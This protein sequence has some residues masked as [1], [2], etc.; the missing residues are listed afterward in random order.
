MASSNVSYQSVA[1]K[2]GILVGVAH[3]IFFLL[4]WAL[5]LLEVTELSFV[6]GLFLVI[7][8]CVALAN[9]KRIKGGMIHYLQ[10]L[11]IGA[12]VGVVSSSVLALFLMLFLSTFGRNYLESLQANALFPEGLS[13]LSLM[14]LTIVY[15]TVPGLLIG[16]IAMQ[17]FKRRDHT[18]PGQM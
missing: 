13:I 8:I 12:T 14:V 7:G 1:I 18:M 10:G 16:F 11:G 15:G 9:F 17:W 2:Y 3:I 6:S 4:M 5:G